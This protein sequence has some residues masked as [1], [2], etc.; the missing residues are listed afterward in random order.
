MRRVQQYVRTKML[1]KV[2]GASPYGGDL[3]K[4]PALD[5]DVFVILEQESIKVDN[6]MLASDR[7]PKRNG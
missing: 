7:P 4:W 1:Y 3:N 5:V 2:S 6:L